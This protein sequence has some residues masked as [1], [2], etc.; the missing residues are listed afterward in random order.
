LGFF[1]SQLLQPSNHGNLHRYSSIPLDRIYLKVDEMKLCIFC[2][3]SYGDLRDAQEHGGVYDVHVE[4]DLRGN[5]LG[6]AGLDALLVAT[7][8]MECL[9][10]AFSAGFLL[11]NDDGSFLDYAEYWSGS[12]VDFHVYEVTAAGFRGGDDTTDDRVIW[13]LSKSE[14]DV[15][16]AIDGTG[17]KFCGLVN[18]GTTICASSTVDDVHFRLPVQLGGFREK[19]A[20]FRRMDLN[21][22]EMMPI[23]SIDMQMIVGAY[24]VPET[25]AEWKWVERNASFKHTRLGQDGV[26]EYILN[27]SLTFED[28]PDIL[29]PFI[30]H[31]QSKGVGYFLFHQGT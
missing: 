11:T 9:D 4:D 17:A 15:L 8:A 3:G 21:A 5:F 27:L 26:W 30:E 31:A 6:G 28:T 23:V 10:G 24:E 13:V 1:L 16:R 14:A 7:K 12:R 20:E 29:K 22:M 19:L 2:M 25:V 18:V